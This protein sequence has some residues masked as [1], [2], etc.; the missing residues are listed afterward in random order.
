MSKTKV[1]SKFTILCWATFT[2]SWAAYGLRAGHPCKNTGDWL[3]KEV[4]NTVLCL[5][6]NPQKSL[7]LLLLEE[8]DECFLIWRRR[9]HWTGKDKAIFSTLS[10]PKARILVAQKDLLRGPPQR[11]PPRPF[12]SLVW[13]SALTDPAEGGGTLLMCL[14]SEE[15]PFNNTNNSKPGIINGSLLQLATQTLTSCWLPHAARWLL[16]HRQVPR[17][18]DPR[19]EMENLPRRGR[20]KGTGSGRYSR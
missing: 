16:K 4:G 12:S 18:E 15:F 19:G 10:D 17:S 3:L 6:D 5:L 2:A 1:L 11:L 13:D 9:R 8:F 20:L 14:F 7:P